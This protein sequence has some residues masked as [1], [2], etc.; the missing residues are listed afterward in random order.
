MAKPAWMT[1][2][3]TSGSGTGTVNVGAQSHTGRT[4]RSGQVT[5]KAAGVT[6]RLLNVTQAAK[7]EFVTIQNATA[8]QGGGNVTLTGVSNT[9]RLNFALGTG[10]IVLTLPPSFTAGGVSTNNN[11]AIAG[12]PGAVAEYEF[13]IT[14]NVPANAGISSLQR[15]I[16]VT[17]MGGQSASATITQAAGE[18]TL[19]INPTT[20]ELN[21]NGDAVPVTVT[22]NTNWTVE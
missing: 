4:P 5:F 8:P 7:A 19:T 14:I 16:Q 13:A 17:A 20:I 10:E 3:P 18:P 12:D 1:T 21:A 15:I 22:S 9:S 2:T 11:V 6:D